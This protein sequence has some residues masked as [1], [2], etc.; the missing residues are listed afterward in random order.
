MKTSF[1]IIVTAF[2]VVLSGCADSPATEQA[3]PKSQPAPPQL[4]PTVPAKEQETI[5]QDPHSEPSAGSSSTAPVVVTP[6]SS[7]HPSGSAVQATPDPS[8]GSRH[9]LTEDE[10]ID[11]VK[12]KLS[13]NALRVSK[14]AVDD[15]DDQGNIVIRQYSL[16][17]T[18]VMEWYHVNPETGTITC[19]ILE[20]GC[21]E[22]KEDEKSNP[23][24]SKLTPEQ[25]QGLLLAREFAKKH[26]TYSGYKDGLTL[27]ELNREED[28]QLQFQV[29]NPGLGGSDTVDWITVDLQHKTV[30]SMF[31]AEDDGDDQHSDDK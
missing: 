11:L 13:K 12:S 6:S 1:M 26:L 8:Q 25:E 4:A 21:L 31:H 19:E 28:G 3:G 2:L 27:V 14:I 22:R 10:V 16:A 20:R 5:G 9:S 24:P 15:R 7:S 18:E 30:E 29:Y 23:A 17:T